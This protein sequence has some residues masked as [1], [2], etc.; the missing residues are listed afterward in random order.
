MIAYVYSL[1]SGSFLCK[2]CEIDLNKPSMLDGTLTARYDNKRLGIGIGVATAP[3]V[4]FN[5]IVWLEERDDI[6]AA[7]ILI[8]HQ[9]E[10][11]AKLEERI[12][13]HKNKI[14]MLSKIIKEVQNEQ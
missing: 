6:R 11:M 7:D 2:K 13:N 9:K 10:Q 4:V 12:N 14:D 5:N 3:G 8:I 1:W